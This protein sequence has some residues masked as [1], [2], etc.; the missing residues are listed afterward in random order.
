MSIGYDLCK[1]IEDEAKCLGNEPIPKQE[2]HLDVL[3]QLIKLARVKL[4]NT[5]S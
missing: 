2:H 5:T 1:L 4:R 3:E